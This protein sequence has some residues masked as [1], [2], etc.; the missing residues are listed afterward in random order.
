MNTL[1]KTIDLSNV[2]TV[3]YHMPDGKSYEI[4]VYALEKFLEFGVGKAFDTSELNGV[5]HFFPRGSA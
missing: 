5:V 1:T 3:V 2:N 4:N